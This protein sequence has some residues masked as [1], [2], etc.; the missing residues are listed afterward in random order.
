MKETYIG[1][2]EAVFEVG[3]WKS[4]G[5]GF[6]PEKEIH[7]VIMGDWVK[8]IRPDLPDLEVQ[9]IDSA[10]RSLIQPPERPPALLLRGLKKKYVPVGSLVYWFERDFILTEVKT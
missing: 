5:I 7:F 6:L 3:G 8:L 2:V 1:T 4:L 10:S 9:V